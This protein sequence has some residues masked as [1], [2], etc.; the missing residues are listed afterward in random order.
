VTGVHGFAWNCP[1]LGLIFSCA[2]GRPG[3][4]TGRRHGVID[5]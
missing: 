1:I 5:G 2:I 3:L 4:S